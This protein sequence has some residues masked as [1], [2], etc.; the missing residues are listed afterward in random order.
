MSRPREGPVEGTG[1]RSAN[2]GGGKRTA[3]NNAGNRE[4]NGL[5][6]GKNK[7]NISLNGRNRGRAQT[8]RTGSIGRIEYHEEQKGPKSEEK[9]VQASGSDKRK[10]LPPDESNE[11]GCTTGLL[12]RKKTCLVGGE[13]E[14]VD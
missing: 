10:D 13:Q 5:G 14:S 4:E 1:H 9:S 2:E 3:F 11:K 7:N 8:R 6:G 12:L